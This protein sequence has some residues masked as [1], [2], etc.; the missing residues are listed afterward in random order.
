DNWGSQVAATSSPITG[1][2]TAANPITLQN[3]N[4]PGQILIWDGASW[5][6]AT[7][8]VRNGLTFA[9]APTPAIELGGNLIRN[10][11]IALG[12]FNLTFTGVTGNIGIGTANPTERLHVEGNLRL[13]GAF[14]PNNLPGTNGSLLLS[15]GAGAPPVWLAPGAVGSILII[16]PG[17]TPVWAPNPIC[18][19]ATTN[20]IMKFTSPTSTCNTTLAENATN[21]IWNQGDGP[22]APGPGIKF[23]IYGSGANPIAILGFTAAGGI[24]GVGIWGYNASATGTGIAGSGNGAVTTY[25][26]P[27]GSGGSFTGTETGLAAFATNDAGDREAAYLQIGINVPQGWLVGSS[28]MGTTYKIVGPGQVSTLVSSPGNFQDKI[29]FAPEAPEVVFMDFGSGQLQNGQA[30]IALDPI[31]ANNIVVN[32]QHPLRV[33]IQLEDECEGV[34]VTNKSSRGFEVRELRG[35][36]SNA[37]FSWYVIANRKDE[38]EPTTGKIISRHEGLRFPPAPRRHKA[39]RITL[40]TPQGN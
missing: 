38:V 26:V 13:Q 17:G 8:A 19:T 36:R 31:F 7:P 30:Y 3:G 24:S 11:D 6:I 28:F 5:T 2:G 23:S 16:G 33:Y 39:E 1:N 32:E 22:G 4:A 10:T 25:V 29:M 35:G 18:V 40:P 34:Y 12:G 37:R 9:L 14:M 21:Q 20:R 27:N 15:A